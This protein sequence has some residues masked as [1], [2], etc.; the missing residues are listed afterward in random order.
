MSLWLIAGDARLGHLVQRLMPV[1]SASCLDLLLWSL[2]FGSESVWHCSVRRIWPYLPCVHCH[3]SL[4]AGLVCILLGCNLVPCR[5]L[6]LD[7]FEAGHWELSRLAPRL[8][9][10]CSPSF[11]LLSCLPAFS[12]APGS[13]GIFRPSPQ[14]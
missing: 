7:C 8:P 4:C 12:G 5:V 9:L 1:S 3:L 11:V 6:L 2:F 14:S 13:S 10:T